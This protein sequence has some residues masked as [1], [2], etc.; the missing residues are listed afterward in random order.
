MRICF[1]ANMGRHANWREMFDKVEFYR[2][3]IRL[4]SELGHE[5]VLAGHPSNLD[6]RA[7]LYYCWWWGHAPFALALGAIRRKPVLV[8]GAFDYATCREEIPGMCYLDRPRWQQEVL[9]GS[10]RFADA[11]LFISGYEY[12][13]VTHNLRVNNP[14]LAPLAV[15]TEF[16]KPAARID[17]ASAAPP[18]FFSVSWTS[19]TNVIRK[20]VRQTIE[21]FARIAHELPTAKLKLAGKQGDHH[22]KLEELVDEL[23]LRDRVEF[24]GMISDAEKRN[25]Y[26][27]CIAYVQPTLYEG[28]GLAI[29][30]AIACGSRVVTS[31]R[32]AVPEVAGEF[33][34][35]THPKDIDAIAVAMLRCAEA[36]TDNSYSIASHTWIQ[37]QYSMTARRERLRVILE[38]IK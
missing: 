36:P 38:S 29:A 4:L 5:V 6:F 1:Y 22:S 23:G 16:Y 14:V 9:K 37:H 17:D 30:E 20:G 26:Q 24:L 12:D 7:D 15:D 32:G 21:A 19:T 27:R 10:L 11:N 31:D 8:T 33:G 35:C 3:D 2:V 25:H 18:Y 28:F 13:E 34:I